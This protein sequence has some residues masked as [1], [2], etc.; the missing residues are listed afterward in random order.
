MNRAR[1]ES[2][3]SGLTSIASKV[4]ACTPLQEH[5]TTR[6]IANELYRLGRS[7]ASLNVIEGCLGSLED[8]GL[9]L[10]NQS[11]YRRIKP[12][13]EVDRLMPKITKEEKVV[14]KEEKKE[15]SV[16][17]ELVELSGRAAQLAKDLEAVS[18]RAA[19]Q[20]AQHKKETALLEQ[21]RG[22]LRGQG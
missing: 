4:F 22:F 17:D 10:K 1:Y 16:F 2:L 5:W 21:L 11:G 19:E 8:Q 14:P 12:P 20:A 15:V 6:Q 3:V 9:V 7:S 18:V 13:C